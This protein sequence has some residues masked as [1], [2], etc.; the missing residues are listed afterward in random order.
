VSSG[1]AMPWRYRLAAHLVDAQTA[2]TKGTRQAFD[3][4]CHWYRHPLVRRHVC[5]LVLS[6]LVS[7]L[8]VAS[9]IVGV[10]VWYMYR[11]PID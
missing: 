3:L 1:K 11:F 7:L 5:Y 2:T 9:C 6:A 4:V 10:L 8:L